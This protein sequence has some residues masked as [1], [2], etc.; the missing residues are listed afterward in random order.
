MRAK[1]GENARLAVL[2]KRNV[3][4]I[5]DFESNEGVRLRS[6]TGQYRPA[7]C[8]AE[9]L[10]LLAGMR[11]QQLDA[12]LSE[13]LIGRTPNSISTAEELLERIR[14]IKKA[15]YATEDEECD[16]GTRCI[17]APIRSAEGRVIAALGFAG[18]RLRLKKRSFPSLAEQVVG[19]AQRLSQQLGYEARQPIYVRVNN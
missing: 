15:G 9:G 13:P 14:R 3:V 1:L 17:A 2:S 8:T 6:I 11:T 12:F 19:F 4:F 7:H 16:I 10:C 5:H 18:P